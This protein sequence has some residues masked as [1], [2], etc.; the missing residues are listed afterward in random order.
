M[1]KIYKKVCFGHVYI[2]TATSSR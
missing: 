2:K 1:T